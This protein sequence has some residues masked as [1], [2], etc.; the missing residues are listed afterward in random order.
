VSS[1]RL[2]FVLVAPAAVGLFGA[3]L[4]PACAGSAPP[5]LAA[6]LVL[7]GAG[8]GVGIWLRRLVENRLRDLCR[9]SREAGEAVAWEK[10]RVALGGLQ[11]ICRESLPRWSRHLEMSRRQ[12]ESAVSGLA[13]EF[14]AILSHLGNTLDGSRRGADAGE[15]GAVIAMARQ[16]L[17]GVLAELQ[18]A[19]GAKQGLLQEISKLSGV[20]EDLTRMAASVGEIAGQTNLLALNAAIE[21]A[22][23][24]EAGRGFAAVADEVHKLSS[25]SGATGRHI[26]E[27]M[28]AAGQTMAKALQAAEKMS[29]QDRR[30]L[31]DCSRAIGQVLDRFKSTA[32]VLAAHSRVL[33]EE[34]R[35]IREE[36]EGVLANLRS[37]GRVSQILSAVQTGIDRLQQR[38]ETDS[39][40]LATGKCPPPIDTAAWVEEMKRACAPLEQRGHVR[41]GPRGPAGQGE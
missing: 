33:N 16:S 17:S 41:G 20:T 14:D 13:R 6:A 35:R 24:G 40:I 30:V 22:R 25:L 32:E 2:S 27:K 26:R 15:V 9:A 11:T 39:R 8:V 19:V 21:A 3:A 38:V 7:A 10:A 4:L 1:E 36:V 31:D 37:Q 34:G 12:T 28:D 5:V 18:A 29:E 23:A